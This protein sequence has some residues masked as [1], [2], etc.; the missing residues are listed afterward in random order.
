MASIQVRALISSTLTIGLGSMILFAL[1]L[2][3]GSF[4]VLDLGLATG[5]ALLLDGCLSLLFFCQHSI[6]IRNSMRLRLAGVVPDEYY[7]AFYALTSGMALLAVMVFWQR[8]PQPIAAAGGIWSWI[9]RALFF[10]SLAGFHWGVRSLGSFDALG[11]KKIRRHL[12]NKATV[13]MPLAV[14]GAYRWVRHP[15]YFFCLV[16]IWSCPVL[17]ADRLLFNVLWTLWIVAGTVLE[18]RD[19]VREFGEQYRRYQAQVPMLIPYKAP[20]AEDGRP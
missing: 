5:Q 15:L 7:S 20:L 4:T 11:I 14:R 16:M 8:T 12:Q 1:F 10:L 3:L 9:L 18:E 6:M 13:P 2:F 19:L 17:T